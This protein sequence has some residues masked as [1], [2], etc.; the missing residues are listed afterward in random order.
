VGTILDAHPNAVVAHEGQIFRADENGGLTGELGYQDRE[1]LYRYLTASS[2]RHRAKGRRGR[3]RE[4]PFPLIAGASNGVFT[5]LKMIGVKRGQEPPIAWAKNPAIFDQLEALVGVPVRLLHVYRNPW[6][7]IA[8]MARTRDR[9][10]ARAASAY[11]AGARTMQAIKQQFDTCD[12]ALEDLI[13]DPLREIGALLDLFGLE[14]EPD[15]LAKA[16]AAVDESPTASRYEQE[17][18]GADVELVVRHKRHIPWLERYPDS[19]Q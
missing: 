1:E 12:L 16:A 9:V 18:T 19:P 14:R 11:F 13:A 3:R 15:F 4:A 8:S 10:A 17:W 7:N 5:E 6:D 2:A